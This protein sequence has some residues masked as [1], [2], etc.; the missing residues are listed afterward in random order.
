MSE[1]STA[2]GKIAANHLLPESVESFGPASGVAA[3]VYARS[4][5]PDGWGWWNSG[6]SRVRALVCL[7]AVL[8][9]VS[10]RLVYGQRLQTYEGEGRQPELGI[11]GP[12]AP[13]SDWDSF[14]DPLRVDIGTHVTLPHDKKFYGV[15][16]IAMQEEGDEGCK[17][18]LYGNLLDPDE[19]SSDILLGSG[20]L[21]GCDEQWTSSWRAATLASQSNTFIRSVRACYSNSPW[22][23]KK[24]KGLM[25]SGALLVSTD[26]QL[27]S[28]PEMPCID[29]KT[30]HCF[31]RP[32]CGSWHDVVYCPTGQILTGV[33]VYHY[34]ENDKPPRAISAI[35]P[36][37][38]G[39]RL[40]RG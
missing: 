39:V 15:T 29:K 25:V 34:A 8:I 28:L 33:T 12:N 40:G 23:Q 26:G 1:T 14:F 20:V 36:W 32:N 13:I 10:P 7:L 27:F 24:I 17:V 22:I 37:C 3:R 4:R 19:P 6:G 16:A 21:F 35:Q 5:I 9:L 38:Q 18:E 31:A 11:S 2:K 30:P